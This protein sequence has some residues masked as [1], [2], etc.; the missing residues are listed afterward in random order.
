M[1]FAAEEITLS[2]GDTAWLLVSSALA[3]CHDARS[4]LLL[5]WPEPVEERAEH[6][7]DELRHHG[8][9]LDPVA[10]LRLHLG[11]SALTSPLVPRRASGAISTQ[12]LG[13][14]EPRQRDGV[15][16][17]RRDAHSDVRDHGVPDDVRH[18]HGGPDQS[19]RSRIGPSS[20]AGS[21]SPSAGSRSR[22][23]R[24]PTWCGVAVSSGRTVRSAGLR[25]WFGGAHQRR[26]GRARPRLRPGPACRLAEGELQA[27]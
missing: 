19:G 2:P 7:D 25:R 12:Y 5:R 13:D 20:A 8:A 22:T 16:A 1:L 10:L 24:S 11:P 21:C 3:P 6:D 23:C 18:H 14:E 15:P 26:G 4:G 27:A 9:H 17:L